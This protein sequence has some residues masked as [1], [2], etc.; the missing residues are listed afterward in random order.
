[1]FFIN[2]KKQIQIIKNNDSEFKYW[3]DRYKY[4]DRYP[5]HPKEYYFKMSS[6]FLNQIDKYLKNNIYITGNKIQIVDIAIFPF[7]R[8]F[9]NVDLDLFNTKFSNISN[10]YLKIVNSNRFKKIM[11]KYKFWSNKNEPLIN[12]L[13]KE[14][15]EN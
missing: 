15:Y 13:Y 11:T 1:L 4:F 5:N 14:Y 10:W 9:A 2:T 6:V 7:I 12:N 3:L 8:Q